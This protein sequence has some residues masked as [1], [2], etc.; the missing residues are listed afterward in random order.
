MKYDWRVWCA[1]VT[2]F[3]VPVWLHLFCQC[4]CIYCASVAEFIL[5]VWLQ[6]LCQCDCIILLVRL[7]VFCQCDCINFVNRT[8][9][10]VTGW[11][12]LLWQYDCIHYASVTVYV[13]LVG[14]HLLYHYDCIFATVTSVVT[15][16]YFCTCDRV[17][18]FRVPTR[19]YFPQ[20]E[21]IGFV[22]MTAFVL[23]AWPLLRSMTTLSLL[24][25]CSYKVMPAGMTADTQHTLI[26]WWM[27]TAR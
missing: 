2:A 19:K 27:Y 4:D 26:T 8:E 9:L 22:H 12:H 15:Y 20:R 7:H 3:V 24:L 1:I 14:V 13:L 21:C 5:P 10:I 23:P 16:Q 25:L 11:L 18:I 17:A 6:L